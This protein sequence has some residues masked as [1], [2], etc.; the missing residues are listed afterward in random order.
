MERRCLRRE[1]QVTVV[2][3]FRRPRAR[4]VDPSVTDAGHR[5][6]T[7]ADVE[8]HN[9]ERRAGAD[10]TPSVKADRNGLEHLQA[11]IRRARSL[12]SAT[13]IVGRVKYDG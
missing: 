2:G 7:D 8:T 10:P 9:E 11:P 5:C 13:V 3:D 4:T 6:G 1:N 12:R